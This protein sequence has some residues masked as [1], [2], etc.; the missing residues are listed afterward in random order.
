MKVIIQNTLSALDVAEM[1]K[2]FI[3]NYEEPIIYTVE[4]G[5]ARDDFIY[6]V[7][8]KVEEEAE[9]RYTR[10]I[11]NSNELVPNVAKWTMDEED[12]H[13]ILVIGTDKQT[14]HIALD[15]PGNNT[16]YTLDIN[17]GTCNFDS[18]RFWR[19]L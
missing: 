16:Y 1:I 18:A 11:G 3:K 12:M 6:K 15:L 10:I 2:E 5:T 8:R 19:S 14:K 7:L 9:K 4:D 17:D 13:D